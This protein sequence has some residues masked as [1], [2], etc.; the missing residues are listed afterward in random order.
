MKITVIAVGKVKE[1]YFRN[2][3]EEYAK[4]ISKFADFRLIE[5]ADEKTPESSSKQE[6]RLILEKEGKRILEKIPADSYLFATAIEG[7][8]FTSTEFAGMLEKLTVDGNSSFTF[9]IGGSLGLMEEL[10]EMAKQK[11][12]FSEMTFPHQLMRVILS[13]QIYRAF[14]IINHEPYHK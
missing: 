3:I 7:K 2:A 10:K 11:I 4:R 9:L 14:K 8:Q 5:V 12:S 6:Q 13:E 1:I